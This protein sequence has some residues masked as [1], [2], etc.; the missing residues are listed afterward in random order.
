MNVPFFDL[1]RQYNSIKEEIIDSINEVLDSQRFI[2]G[3]TVEE[4]E[5]NISKYCN[6]KH[7]IGVASGTDALLLSLRAHEISSN[8]L[9][10]TF[11]FFATAGAIYNA[12]ANPRF[13]DIDQKHSI[14]TLRKVKQILKKIII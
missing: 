11:T 10:S 12:R 9:T 4:F 6:C 8:V 13:A 14:L 1:K 2:M 5:E 3:E 7:A